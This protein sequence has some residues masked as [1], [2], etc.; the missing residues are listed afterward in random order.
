MGIEPG[1]AHGA[2]RLTPGR[3]TTLAD[4]DRAGEVLRASVGRM[5]GRVAPRPEG[6]P[7]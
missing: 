2:L 4:V 5:R 7:A 6:A 1:P 3:A